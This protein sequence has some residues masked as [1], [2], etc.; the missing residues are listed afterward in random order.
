[1]LEC[2]P[3]CGCNEVMLTT[4]RHSFGFMSH[5]ECS[6]CGARGGSFVEETTDESIERATAD[7]NQKILR[8]VTFREKLSRFFTQVEYDLTCLWY[9]IRYWDW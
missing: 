4:K 3:F 9:K 8:S 1:M 6:H 7:W 2:C 5:V